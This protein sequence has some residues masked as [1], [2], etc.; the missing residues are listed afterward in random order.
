M[1]TKNTL[2]NSALKSGLLI[3]AVSI[4]T[5]LIMYVFDIKPVGLL[6]PILLLLVSIAISIV[7]LVILLKKYRVS[8]GG[9]ISFRNAFLFAFLAFAVSVILYQGFNYIFLQLVDPEYNKTIMEA[10]K[11]WMEGYLSGKMSDEQI[12]EQLDKLDEQA[13]KMGSFSTLLKN[14]L[15]S[16]IVFGIVALIV[17]AIMKKKPDMFETTDGGAI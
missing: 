1:E 5:F 3:G 17:G 15:G 6:I 13:A 4:V 14:T 2:F 10:Q 11:T 9:F 12:A 8:S 7:I 16:I